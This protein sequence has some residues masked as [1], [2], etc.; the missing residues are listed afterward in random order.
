MAEHKLYASWKLSR[1]LPL[2]IVPRRRHVEEVILRAGSLIPHD[3][4]SPSP[5]P[6]WRN[7]YPGT[8]LAKSSKM[9]SP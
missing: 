3:E 4:F 5:L 7:L 9:D 1:S 2:D 6:A 8:F